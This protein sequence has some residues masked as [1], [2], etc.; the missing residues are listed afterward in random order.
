MSKDELKVTDAKEA[1]AFTPDE[2]NAFFGSYL[3]HAIKWQVGDP[4]KSVQS[5]PEN[6]D[7]VVSVPPFGQRYRE[8]LKI[9]IPEGEPVIVNDDLSGLIIVSSIKKLKDKGRGLFVVTPRFFTSSN[10]VLK[11]FDNLG[12]GI[13]AALY[14]PSGSFAPNTSIPTYLLILRNQKI[15]KMF[16]AELAFDSKTNSQ[17]LAN[18]R[19]GKEGGTL[20]LG[21]LVDPQTFI[22]WEQLKAEE[23]IKQAEKRF[24]IK[25]IRLGDVALS[26]TMGRFDENFH[27]TRQENQLFIPTIGSSNVVASEDGLKLKNQ[28]YAQVIIDPSQSYAKF[29]SSFL[30]TEFGKE[31]RQQGKRGAVIPKLNKT[32]ISDLLIIIPSL[33]TQQAIMEV[34]ANIAAEKNVLMSLQNELENFRSIMWSHPQ[35]VHKVSDNLRNF[36]KRLSSSIKQHTSDSI[37]QW[38]E[39]LPFPLASIL[40]KW[41]AIPEQ[42]YKS[43]QE[44]LMFFF[45]A[46][47]EFT[48]MILLS[49]FSKNEVYFQPHKQKIVETLEDQNLSFQRASFGVWKVVGEYLGKQT[50]Y[51]TL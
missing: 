32:S 14:M 44:M 45:E 43:K 35:S 28:N 2:I 17:I 34:E 16:V 37:E 39:T 25:P 20:E 9:L 11:S 10:S 31:V 18:L 24:G 42:D 26:I 49:A 23:K 48:D 38:F 33:Q 46:L 40:R 8:A 4:I 21:R 13:E 7:I 19:D 30:N 1:V 50:S 47:F 51:L 3:N 12:I 36:S 41:Q 5:L 29:V 6:F 15:P 22:G 27:F